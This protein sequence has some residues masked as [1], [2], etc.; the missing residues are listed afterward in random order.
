MKN[1]TWPFFL[2][3]ISVTFDPIKLGLMGVSL[4]AVYNFLIPA[5]L[6]ATRAGILI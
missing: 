3:T 5:D 2:I 4:A 1:Q 6:S